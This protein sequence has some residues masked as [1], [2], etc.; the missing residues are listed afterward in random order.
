MWASPMYN[1]DKL[2]VE[3]G[4]IVDNVEN[5]VDIWDFEYPSFYQGADKKAFER[6]VID[7]FY[8]RQ[9]GQETVG[10]FLHMF[11]TRIL[12]IMPYYNRM[13]KSVVLMDG[14]ENPFDNVDVT[15]TFESETSGQSTGESNGFSSTQSETTAHG[16]TTIERAGTENQTL[17]RGIT[18][19][20][21]STENKE[22]RFSNTPQGSIS[23][24]DNYLTEASK[25]NTSLDESLNN[26]TN[27]TQNSETTESSSSEIIDTTSGTISAT[28]TGTAKSTD[29]ATTKHTLT[30]KG[31]QGVNTYAHDIIEYRKS[32]IDIDMMI[33]NNLQDLFLGVY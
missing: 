3:L 11:K 21:E 7:H 25:D 13:Y 4:K 15:E 29:S 8:F 33:I 27:E 9:I 17:S 23:N 31:N 16:E 28:T 6:K 32:I 24:L 22:H 12:E 2:T 1:T 18:E 10:R 26:E 14:L 19:S 5:P 30:R 20:K